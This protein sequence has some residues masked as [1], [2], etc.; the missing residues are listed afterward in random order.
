MPESEILNMVS[1]PLLAIL[2]NIEGKKKSRFYLK[3]TI[4]TVIDFLFFV[5]EIK[6][7]NSK[8]S[9]FI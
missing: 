3:S 1:S 5:I 9:M 2:G 8:E 6:H 4:N 7:F